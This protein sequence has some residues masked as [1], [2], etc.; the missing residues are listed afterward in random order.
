MALIS[1]GA[2]EPIGYLG[3]SENTGCP[4]IEYSLMGRQSCYASAISGL[5][6]CSGFLP[7]SFIS[8]ALLGSSK[9]KL[10]GMLGSIIYVPTFSSGAIS[11]S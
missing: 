6:G 8:M 9:S 10:E 2:T 1:R 11:N 5:K 4:L 7:F 3:G